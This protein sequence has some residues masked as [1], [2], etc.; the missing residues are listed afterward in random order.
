MSQRQLI[1]VTTFCTYHNI[2]ITFIRE[3]AEYDLVEI[4]NKEGKEFFYFDKIP[5]VEKFIRLHFDL[6][7]NMEGLSAV[8]H[9]LERIEDLQQEVRTLRNRV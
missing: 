2:E 7:I 8:Y 9:L 4:V 5:G 6:K 3:L 1:E